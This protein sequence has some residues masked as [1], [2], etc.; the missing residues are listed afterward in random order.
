MQ[1]IGVFASGGGSNLQALID[2]FNH[3]SSP[4]AR[5]ALVVSDRASAGALERARRAGIE[6]RVIE[7]AGRSAD[8]VAVR[9]LATLAEHDVTIVALAGYLRLVPEPLVQA[10]R[11]RILNIHPA[12]LPAFGGRGMYGTRVHRAV[13]AAGCCVTGA[14]VHRVDERYDEGKPVLQWPVPVL[15]GDTAESLAARVLRIEHAIYPVAVEAVALGRD[16][17]RPFAGGNDSTFEWNGDGAV[18]TTEELRNLL[19]IGRTES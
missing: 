2:H 10:F 9:T 3:A 7:P 15:R 17:E 4:I 5:V 1:S 6:A 19:E 16:P 11:N 13:L 18:P 12:L 8:G 14:T